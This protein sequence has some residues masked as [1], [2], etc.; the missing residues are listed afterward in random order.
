LKIARAIAAKRIPGTARPLCQRQQ[1][2]A[3]LSS[4]LRSPD[5]K[6]AKEK[7]HEAI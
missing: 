2:G 4:S 7:Y 5:L 6:K 1:N 3:G